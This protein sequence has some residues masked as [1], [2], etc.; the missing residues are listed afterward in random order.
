LYN[1]IWLITESGTAESKFL[2]LSSLNSRSELTGCE[3]DEV[4]YSAPANQ[5]NV[6][7][8]H[9]VGLIDQVKDEMT[10]FKEKV[11]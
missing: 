3:D 10:F 6:R 7:L 11:L 4:L 9:V 1:Q 5:S 8:E 2:P